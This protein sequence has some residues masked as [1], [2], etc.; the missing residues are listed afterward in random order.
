M[1]DESEIINLNECI[2]VKNKDNLRKYKLNLDLN[3]VNK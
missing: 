2:E 1:C 3:K